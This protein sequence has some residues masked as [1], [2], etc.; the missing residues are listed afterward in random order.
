VNVREDDK[1]LQ[2]T[3][4]VFGGVVVSP[5]A[6]TDGIE[7]F[8]GQLDHSLA[9]WKA[10]GHNLVWL[11]VP[12]AKASLI[13]VAVQSGFVF[14]H[15]D[16]SGAVMTRRLVDAAYFPPYA[17]HYIG[18][19]GVVLNEEE[20]LLV[21]SERYRRRNSGPSY[22][23]PGGAL[24]PGEHLV[25]GV[26][27]EIKEETGVHT[28]FESVVCFRHWHGYRFGKSDIY[29]VCRLSPLSESISRQ[30]EEIDECRWMPV[31]E[32]LAADNVSPFNK[33][34]VRAAM[35]SNGVAPTPMDG[36]DDHSRFEFFVPERPIE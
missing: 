29:F 32:Y 22:K 24:H 12:A 25:D 31:R 20:E 33:R 3:T 17:T 1:I 19:G 30:V 7:R 36:Y 2:S 16:E 27:R 8:G 4:N 21:V 13:P 15:A 28:R 11:E 6:L 34:I 9:A 26:V 23:L 14:H 5:E 35:D 18:V 10:A